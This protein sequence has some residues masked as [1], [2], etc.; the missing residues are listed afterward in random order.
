LIGVVALIG[1]NFNRRGYGG[2]IA[3][4]M[5]AVLA[6][7]LPGFAFQQL[8]NASP[9]AVPLMY[10]WPMLWIVGLMLFLSVPGFEMLR[11]GTTA[12]ALPA[13]AQQ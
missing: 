7:R 5:G 9:D 10:I 3:L 12:K 2:R 1:G 8:T 4:A 11:R 6:A 13:G